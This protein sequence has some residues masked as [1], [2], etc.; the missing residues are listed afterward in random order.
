VYLR[1]YDSVSDARAQLAALI[2][3]YNTH[4]PHS[5][6]A[7]KTPDEFLLRDAAGDSTGSLSDRGFH[8]SESEFVF[9]VPRPALTSANS[10]QTVRS[11]PK[12]LRTSACFL[13]ESSV[14]PRSALGR[15][16]TL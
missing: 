11:T 6:L 16:E 8:L 5:S 15:G 14:S 10:C 7:K 3:F 1:A 12:S 4:R 13:T 9:K 2:E